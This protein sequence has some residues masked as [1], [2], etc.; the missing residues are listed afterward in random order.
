MDDTAKGVPV[1]G[2][3]MPK[4]A[5]VF[6]GLKHRPAVRMAAPA[7]PRAKTAQRG[8]GA[9]WQ[10]AS[11]AYLDA[12]PTCV[13]C[14]QPIDRSKGSDDRGCVDHEPAHKGDMGRF[15]DRATW[16]PAHKRCHNRKTAM[17][18][19]GWGNRAK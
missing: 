17:V 16:R 12:H 18:D 2:L 13:L 6:T 4:A 1:R 3:V 5:K 15:W 9:A 8:Y 19:G 7:T 14:G 11:N 10:R